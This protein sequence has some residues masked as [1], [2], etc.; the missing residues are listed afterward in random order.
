MLQNE[1]QSENSYHTLEPPTKVKHSSTGICNV[2]TTLTLFTFVLQN[3]K[4]QTENAYHILE[5]PNR[6]KYS[7]VRTI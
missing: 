6:V 1:E 2:N 5:Q 3:N 7:S 4:E